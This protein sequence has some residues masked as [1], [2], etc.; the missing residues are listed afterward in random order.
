MVN[1]ARL[2]PHESWVARVDKENG[3]A[4]KEI[5]LVMSVDISANFFN[6]RLPKGQTLL[7]C[8]PEEFVEI[9]PRRE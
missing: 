9:N 2:R 5:G 7:R 6:I 3:R 8:E 4:T 1:V